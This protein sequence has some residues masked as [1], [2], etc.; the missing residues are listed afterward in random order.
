MHGGEENEWWRRLAWPR[1][2]A[3]T[4]ELARLNQC[5]QGMLSLPRR[6]ST[7]E[8]GLVWSEKAPT[9]F[10]RPF[11]EKGFWV[12]REN[13]LREVKRVQGENEFLGDNPKYIAR[14]DF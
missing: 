8:G 14:R 7:V 5:F 3:C 4:Q 2:V 1:R 9:M 11:V 13:V 6:C 12:K 10:E